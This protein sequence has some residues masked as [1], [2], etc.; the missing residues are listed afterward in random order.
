MCIAI[1]VSKP[2]RSEEYLQV[3]GRLIAISWRPSTILTSRRPQLSSLHSLSLLLHPVS[4][5]HP[6]YQQT[7]PTLLLLPHQLSPTPPL[8]LLLLENVGNA[9]EQTRQHHHYS[10]L[11]RNFCS[12]RLYQAQV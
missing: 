2:P 8:P 7:Y 10:L 11:F 6:E 3:E 4:V 1:N 12:P 9:K 5:Q